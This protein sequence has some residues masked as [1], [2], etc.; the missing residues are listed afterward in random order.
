VDGVIGLVEPLK[1]LVFFHRF[2][3][4][5]IT[6]CFELAHIKHRFGHDVLFGGP[7]AQIAVAAAF[8]AKGKIRVEFGISRRFANWAA[9]FIGNDSDG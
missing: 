9:M 5:R 7:V 6:T 4:A 3:G 2:F 8:A 1:I